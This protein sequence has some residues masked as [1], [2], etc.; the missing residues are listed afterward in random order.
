M[1]AYILLMREGPTP[2]Q[3]VELQTRSF[4]IGRD[5]AA[6]LIINDVEVSRRH[7]RLI[8]QSGGYAIEDLGS[9][10]GTFVNEQRIRTVV[11]LQPGDQVRL[12]DQVVLSYEL[13][14]DDGTN[15]RDFAATPPSIS[16][17]MQVRSARPAPVEP[18][19]EPAPRPA[20]RSIPAAPVPAAQ[21]LRRP[22]AAEP[23][24]EDQPPAAPARAR[25]R[26]GGL[27]LPIFSRRWM[28]G[29]AVIALLGLC[30]A[31]AMFWYIDANFL[32]CDVF[33]TVIPACR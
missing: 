6:N 8:A 32:W 5:P 24:Y 11:T 18:E 28:I 3:R 29:C 7:T 26:R 15:T 20:A 30:A 22:V 9:T 10:N 33:G 16:A 2:G 4:V 12:G 14:D 17:R 27:R 23:A 31:V 19:P 1:P 21:P 25:A 13:L